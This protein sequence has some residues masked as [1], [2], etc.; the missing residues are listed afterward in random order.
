MSGQLQTMLAAE[1]PDI[2]WQLVSALSWLY[3]AHMFVCLS[4]ACQGPV[5]TLIGEPDLR[6]E[7]CGG[8]CWNLWWVEI[9]LPP[10]E[11][12]QR[13]CFCFFVFLSLCVFSPSACQRAQ[14]KHAHITCLGLHKTYIFF[15]YKD[16]DKL[17]NR[18][19]KGPNMAAKK[20]AKIL[21]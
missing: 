14:R 4:L 6:Q 3:L 15:Q 19:F 5:L 1:K 21:K 7:V 16:V 17:K 20:T 12:K 9:S 11:P 13:C 10:L 2:F 18:L 8:K